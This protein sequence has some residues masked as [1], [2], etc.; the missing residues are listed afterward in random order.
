VTVRADQ[1][2]RFIVAGLYWK[3]ANTQG[4]YFA[5]T[6]GLVSWISLEV[7]QPDTYWPPQLVGLLL[8]AAGMA[9]GS[10][11]PHFVGKPTPMV[12]AHAYLHAHASHLH[13]HE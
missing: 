12:P 2:Q 10:L 5:M 3:R 11:V 6:A 1:R 9:L 7:L 8:S 13:K 4:A